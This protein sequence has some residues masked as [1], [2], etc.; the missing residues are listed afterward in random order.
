M[1]RMNVIVVCLELEPE[2]VAI[3]DSRLPGEQLTDIP[4]ASRGLGA[5]VRR[6]V[7]LFITPHNTGLWSR[8][9]VV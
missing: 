4:S 6:S 3:L 5:H 9:T 1:K 2:L 7:G 8:V